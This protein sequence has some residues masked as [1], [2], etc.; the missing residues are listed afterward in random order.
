MKRQEIV[1]QAGREIELLSRLHIIYGLKDEPCFAAQKK[2][3]VDLIT[4]R[5]HQCEAG[6]RS[7]FRQ[8]VSQILRVTVKASP[9]AVNAAIPAK[10]RRLFDSSSLPFHESRAA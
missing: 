1:Q 10:E 5:E 8:S 3:I 2:K 9:V 4:R 7:S 6:S